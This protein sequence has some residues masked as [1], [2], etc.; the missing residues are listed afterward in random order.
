MSARIFNQWL[1]ADLMLAARKKMGK[2]HLKWLA[3]L[4]A[5]V[6]R[7]SARNV[8]RFNCHLVRTRATLQFDIM[9]DG[10]AQKPAYESHK[11]RAMRKK[12]VHDFSADRDG[13]RTNI[14]LKFNTIA[15]AAKTRRLRRPQKTHQ[16]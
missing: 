4:S 9:S 3:H 6:M 15:T 11:K 12:H 2:S 8:R 10:V 7:Q 16:T 1:N 5:F 13:Q 14:A